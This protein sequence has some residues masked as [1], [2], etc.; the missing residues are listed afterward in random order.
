MGVLIAHAGDAICR[1]VEMIAIGIGAAGIFRQADRGCEARGIATL[2][3][4]GATDPVAAGLAQPA[5]VCAAPEERRAEGNRGEL[6]QGAA[7]L[8]AGW[9]I[10]RRDANRR[11]ASQP[12]QPLDER[13]A[14]PPRRKDF[15]KPVEGTIVH[16]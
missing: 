16:G 6:G 12:E 14:V 5:A 3:S 1:V 11:G 13:A 15:G 9:T 7:N 10:R 4:P 8:R 2:L